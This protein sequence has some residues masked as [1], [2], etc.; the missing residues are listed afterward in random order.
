MQVG[1]HIRNVKAQL[2]ETS[3]AVVNEIFPLQS[4]A[5]VNYFNKHSKELNLELE[6]T[7]PK[8]QLERDFT[9]GENL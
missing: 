3:N 5:I 4:E 2:P 1:M 6:F 8:S 9:Q 7:I